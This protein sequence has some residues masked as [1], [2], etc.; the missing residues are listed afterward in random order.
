MGQ[1]RFKLEALEPRIMLAADA[2]FVGGAIESLSGKPEESILLESD[3]DEIQVF[4]GFESGGLF[5]GFD[6]V[7]QEPRAEDFDDASN[8]SGASELEA[9]QSEENGA[10]TFEEVDPAV[11]EAVDLDVFEAEKSL[12]VRPQTE[13]DFNDLSSR[14]VMTLNAGNGPPAMGAVAQIMSESGDEDEDLLIKTLAEDFPAVTVFWVSD[15][16]GFWDEA[17][18]WSTGVVPTSSDSVMIDRD[19]VDVTVTVRANAEVDYLVSNESLA[20]TAGNL[21]IS[22]D[23]ELNGATEFSG[24]G[25]FATAITNKGTLTISGTGVKNFGGTLNNEGTISNTGT[26]NLRFSNGIINNQVGA[27]F[28]FAGDGDFRWIGG[29]QGQFNNSGTF[30]KSAGTGVSNMSGGGSAI[31]FNNAAGGI[32]EVQS[33]TLNLNGSGSSLGGDFR[34]SAGAT[35]LI[36]GTGNQFEG[37]FIGSG[38]G[39]VLFSSGTLTLSGATVFDFD[40]GLFVWTGGSISGGS[41]SNEGFVAIDDGGSKFLATTLENEGRVIHEGSENLR[42][43]NGVINNLSGGVYEFAGDGDFRWNSGAQGVFNNS[44]LLLKSSGDG[45]SNMTGGGSEILFN[46][47]ASGTIEARSGTLVFDG[48]GESQGG[49]FEISAGAAVVIE[50]AYTWR[51]SY[52]GSGEGVL[53]LDGGTLTGDD[54]TT[55]NFPDGF[56]EFVSGTLSGTVL[57]VG[58]IALTGSSNKSLSGT[59]NNEGTINNSGTGNLFFTTGVLNNRSGAVYDTSG[60]GDLRWLSGSQ[61][62]FNN[63]GAFRKSAGS[64]TVDNRG[65]GSPIIFNNGVDGVL[66]VQEGTFL[67]NG[68]GQFEGADF[69][70]ASGAKIEFDGTYTLLGDYSGS[71]EGTVE[72]SGGTI[73]GDETTVINLP[74]GLFE[75]SGGALGGEIENTGFL[76]MVGSALRFLDGELN[77]QGTIL[78]EGGGPLGFRNGT[79]NNLS[80]ATFDTSSDGDLRWISGSQGVFNN[81]GT[82][83]KSAGAG[84]VN[85]TG[86]GSA[87]LFN[88]SATGVIEVSEGDLLFNGSGGVF[89]GGTFIVAAGGTATFSKNYTWSG[90]YTGTGEGTVVID[91][92]VITG[93]DTTELDFAEGLLEF[94]SGTLFGEFSNLGFMALTGTSNQTLQGTLNNSGTIEHRG[95]NVLFFS[96]GLLNNLS[97]GTYQFT[98]DG[99]FRWLNG[100]QGQFVNEGLLEKTAG[101]GTSDMRG[102]GSAILFDNQ[103]SVRSASGTLLVNG[104]TSQLSGSTIS[105]GTWIADG[106][107]LDLNIAFNRN[108][109]TLEIAE[110]G[111]SIIDL[112]DLDTN[113]GTLLVRDGA[114]FT[115][116]GNFSNEGVLKLGP[117]GTVDLTGDFTQTSSGTLEAQ[118]G[119]SPASEQFGELMVSG[120]A[121][122]DGTLGLELVNGFGPETGG[123]YQ[124]ATFGFRSGSFAT[125]DGVAPFFNSALGSGSLVLNAI[126]TAS[127]LSISNIA[128]PSNRTPGE[129]AT[130]TYTVTNL[131]GSEAT[132]DWTD[133]V[134]FSTDA[135]LDASD[136]LFSTFS[137]TDN[138]AIGASYNGS[139]TATVP[140]IPNGDYFI[141]VVADSERLLP[142]T[143]RA[144]NE[145]VGAA[146]INIARIPLQVQSVT[147]TGAIVGA[148]STFDITFNQVIDEATLSDEDIIITGPSGAV[149]IGT[150]AS[151]GGNT[152]RVG[153]AAQNSNGEYNISI[154]P[155]IA[156]PGGFLMDEDNDEIRGEVSDDVATF[157][158]TVALPDLVPSNLSLDPDPVESGESL[159]I[160]WR[161]TNEG[162]ESASDG[163]TERVV[164]SQDGVLGNGDDVLLDTIVAGEALASGEFVDRESTV[165]IPIELLG[166]YNL[167]VEVDTEEVIGESDESNQRT[168]ATLEV[169]STT[170]PVDLVITA[171]VVPITT[172]NGTSIEI[173]WTVENQGRVAT[174]QSAWSDRVY[175][176]SD[177]TFG[178]DTILGSFVHNGVLGPGESYTETQLVALSPILA[179]GSYTFFVQT[180]VFNQVSE[181]QGESN[182]VTGSSEVVVTLSPLPDLI[183]ASIAAPAVGLSGTEIDVEWVVENQG[184]ADLS[185]ES[186]IDRV[187]L[188]ANGVVD[189]N[190]RLLGS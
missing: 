168:S 163:W 85:L 156:T 162:D 106:G 5:E 153:F 185:G 123:S 27:V 31:A 80:G 137:R 115:R 16:D 103:G 145:D 50:D 114:T 40:E 182:N 2:A 128:G 44:G 14:M 131:S 107:I 176:S 172:Q 35:L 43:I 175:L 122:L 18:N 124:V 56:F 69:V 143:D 3:S 17:S 9:T 83:R 120:T 144:N 179:E 64:G 54:T 121:T 58:T 118:I 104:V 67:L 102:G 74:E 75:F 174:Q 149:S 150:I 147:P 186:R 59:L 88:N 23:A 165:Q 111:G 90:S 19:G 183:V 110:A 142:D 132:V 171:I 42:F 112:E 91:G 96:S 55:F 151:I 178:S 4:E 177:D 48:K 109:G 26:G 62:I 34:V 169:I 68:S 33:G 140:G 134:Y 117:D 136:T 46:N 113:A 160:N 39:Q 6:A 60:D 12:E 25:L 129:S 57:N 188:T 63:E 93:D 29:T 8:D 28:D 101:D 24:G 37:S 70:V 98:G 97:S 86:G 154:G 11:S 133:S 71:G 130:I 173:S 135:T 148:F 21:S 159:T 84:Q 32:I 47:A 161:V 180:D 190:S 73:S 127:D 72:L 22:S 167:F 41:L 13:S 87:V 76:S 189:G 53:Q 181:P 146:Q 99:N 66:E 51:G 139:V 89:E 38:D 164:L 100:T 105:G 170:P 82:F 95:D 158:V 15:V 116:T 45:V 65:G 187:Y 152:Y 30:R 49:S 166:S 36:T 52:T 126:A 184:Q 81:S 94:E 157:S 20:I 138:L 108:E 7:E 125:E 155:N 61:G 78:H 141:I 10:A 77:N 79:L 92:G 119:G 1:S